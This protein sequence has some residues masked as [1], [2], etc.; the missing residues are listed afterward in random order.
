MIDKNRVDKILKVITGDLSTPAE[1]IDFYDW[2]RLKDFKVISVDF[3]D[4]LYLGDDQGCFEKPNFEMIKRIEEHRAQGARIYI[5]TAR[6]QEYEA[7]RPHSPIVVGDYIRVDDFL[8]EYGIAVDDIIMT[9]LALKGKYLNS[10]GAEVHYDNHL[11]QIASA[12]EHGVFGVP[13]GN[14]EY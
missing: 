10:F 4:C 14:I 11:G 7:M 6:I 9:N 3:D 5:C 2:D 13:F 12:I 8:D 1:K